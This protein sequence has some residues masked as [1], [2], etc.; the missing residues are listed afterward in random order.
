MEIVVDKKQETFD[1]DDYD[2]E[3]KILKYRDI[4]T[5][6]KLSDEYKM[7]IDKIV[8]RTE[9]I[10][11]I[12]EGQIVNGKIISLNRKEM[13]VDI[14]YKDLLYIENKLSDIVIIDKLQI[15][16][17][18]DVL[19]TEISDNPFI[20]KGSITEIIRLNVSEKLKE[21]YSENIPITAVVK[22]MK[23]AGFLLDIEMDNVTSDAFMPT[24]L[25][26]IN[27]L[28]DNQKTELI[29]KRLNVMLETLQQD[30]GIYVVSR[31]KYLQSLVESELQTIK[32]NHDTDKTIVYD[33]IVT[34]TKS[35]GIFVEFNECLTGMI[36]RYNVDPTWTTEEKWRQITPGMPINFY[37]R[38]IILK[39]KKIILTQI[40]RESL[41]DSIKKNKIIEGKII[42]LKPFGALVK[43]DEE[44]N[45]LI[46]NSYIVRNGLSLKEGDD[47]TV[48]VINYS[49]D[50]RKINLGVVKQ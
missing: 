28:T 34:G 18:I 50:D 27:K 41:W 42:K 20:M 4:K 21:C 2:K 16:D 29:G 22:E 8:T 44:T 9:N 33:G 25:A 43:L 31:R 1:F 11:E 26:G 30:K 24:T 6:D 45:G 38:D 46:K 37:V 13:I 36:Y 32:D 48:K 10:T 47:I 17:N 23:P 12:K 40:L 3:N 5:S 49:K 35:F 7:F 39:Y 14:N 19:V 15:G